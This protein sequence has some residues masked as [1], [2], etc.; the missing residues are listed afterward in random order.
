MF[1]VLSL[2]FVLYTLF[3]KIESYE[4]TNHE[5]LFNFAAQFQITNPNSQIITI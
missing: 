4:S 5:L 2:I 3:L 1:T